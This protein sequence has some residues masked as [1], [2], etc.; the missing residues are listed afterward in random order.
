[1]LMDVAVRAKHDPATVF[2]A[3]DMQRLQQDVLSD[4]NRV[5]DEQLQLRS[6]LESIQSYCESEQ[7]RRQIQVENLQS[8]VTEIEHQAVKAPLYRPTISL[9]SRPVDDQAVKD[10]RLGSDL[11]RTPRRG[12]HQGAGSA[13]YR[14]ADLRSRIIRFYQQ[15]NPSKLGSVDGVLREY[16]GAE[17]ELMSALEIH[18]GAF[19]YFSE[20]AR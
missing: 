16:E 4:L 14:P 7:R 18:Y 9:L 11:V 13:A 3:G 20:D 2:A 15:H 12:H 5:R 17:E 6:R 8:T 1:M 10:A 19:G